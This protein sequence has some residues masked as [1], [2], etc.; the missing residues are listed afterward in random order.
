MRCVWPLSLVSQAK[1]GSTTTYRNSASEYVRIFAYGCVE[2]S[3]NGRRQVILGHIPHYGGDA[4][5]YRVLIAKFFFSEPSA[6]ISAE[7][8]VLCALAACVTDL[9]E[10]SRII[11]LDMISCGLL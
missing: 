6:H 2:V 11:M 5:I 4:S 8:D 1:L 9:D 7:I 10:T 3:D